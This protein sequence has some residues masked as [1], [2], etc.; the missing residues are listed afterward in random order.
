MDKYFS[1]EECGL[2]PS[3]PLETSYKLSFI[4]LYEQDDYS[5]QNQFEPTHETVTVVLRNLS[6]RFYDVS[7]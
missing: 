5:Y 6:I 1:T 7:P 4:G 3:L 2:H